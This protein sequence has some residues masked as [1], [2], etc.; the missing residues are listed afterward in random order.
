[1]K[2][3]T[4]IIEGLEDRV[5]IEKNVLIQPYVVIMCRERIKIGRGSFI[6][7]HVTIVDFDHEMT[8][9]FKNIEYHGKKKKINIGR[10]CWIGANAVVLKGVTLG[11]G[12]VVGA[13]SVVTK[14][15]PKGSVI[16]GNPAK[17]LRKRK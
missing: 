7:P 17:L 15:F 16:V 2:H 9:P 8:L 1:M 5:V 3:E 10:H 14:S 12:C 6:S 4:S 11:D 13:G